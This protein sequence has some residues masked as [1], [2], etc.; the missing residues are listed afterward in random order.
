MVGL[1]EGPKMG[2]ELRELPIGGSLEVVLCV[3][4]IAVHLPSPLFERRKKVDI[5]AS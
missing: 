3:K 1:A 5:M 4:T 2:D